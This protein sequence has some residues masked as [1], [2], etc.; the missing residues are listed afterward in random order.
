VE[1]LE[2]ENTKLLRVLCPEVRIFR[3]VDEGVNHNGE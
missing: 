3:L 1:K 2:I